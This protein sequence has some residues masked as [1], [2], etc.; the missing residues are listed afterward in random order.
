MI[1]SINDTILYFF[2]ILCNVIFRVFLL[3]II[4]FFLASSISYEDQLHKL[5]VTR[6]IGPTYIIDVPPSAS[7]RKLTE[8]AKRLVSGIDILF[9]LKKNSILLAFFG[10][11]IH[12]FIKTECVTYGLWSPTSKL[13]S[14]VHL[15]V[16]S[17][18]L[19][20]RQRR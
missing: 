16:C 17:L 9:F 11:K 6:N 12:D 19:V 3:K 10:L 20:Q 13:F 1:I 7:V 18:L 4:N 8:L 14:Q 2:Y 5:E 15:L